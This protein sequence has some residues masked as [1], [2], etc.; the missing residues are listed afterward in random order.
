MAG[1]MEITPRTPIVLR[2][3]IVT[4]VL[5][6]AG[7]I[8]ATTLLSSFLF[9]LFVSATVLLATWEWCGFIGLTGINS[10]FRYSATIAV[11]LLA[12]FLALD[13]RPDTL[14]IDPYRV[15]AILGLGTLFWLLSLIMLITYPKSKSAWNDQSKI[16]SMGLFALIPVWVGV[17]QLKYLM[18]SGFSVIALIVLV[19]AVDVGAYFIGTNF[20]GSK[21]AP[22]VSPSKSWEGVWGGLS[23]AVHTYVENLELWQFIALMTLTLLTT[24]FSIIGDL[25]ESM[26][27]RNQN[28]KDSGR[29]LPGHGGLL[30]RVD[31]L[32]AAA[33]GYTLVVMFVFNSTR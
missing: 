18:P 10:R 9:A 30:D 14:T 26:L 5:L 8:T 4:A 31:G 6:L 21:L 1:M 33:P 16:A 25:V 13:I 15:A 28:L 24:F 20:G 2:Q 17:I 27:K 32:I 12:L 23:W 3:R 11:M 19:A 22:E 29:I 7:L